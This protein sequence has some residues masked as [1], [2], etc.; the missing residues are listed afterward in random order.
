MRSHLSERQVGIRTT[1]LKKGRRSESS[2]SSQGESR[3]GASAPSE[4]GDIELRE[5]LAS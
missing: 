3:K 1:V 4:N 2:P 5:D